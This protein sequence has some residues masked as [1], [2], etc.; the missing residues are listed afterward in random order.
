MSL[1]VVHTRAHLGVTAP[2]V[3][4]E[5]HLSNG[6]PGISIVGMPE[7][8]VRESRER[9]RCAILDS[10]FEYPAR[11]ITVNLAPAALPKSGGRYDLAIAIGILAASGQI[12]AAALSGRELLGELALDGG[13]R[14][15][16]GVLPAALAAREA[17][18]VLLLPE[19][20]TGEVLPVR[21]L[22][23]ISAPDLRGICE[24]LLDDTGS[25]RGRWRT[26]PFD[27]PPADMPRRD[28]PLR[29][30]R[31]QRLAKR[32]ILVAA[33]GGH[34]LLLTGPPGAGKTLLANALY[35]LLPPLSEEQALEVA[36]IRSVNAGREGPFRC[37]GPGGSWYQ[38][39]L[40]APHHKVTGVALTGG[41]ATLRPGEVTLA[42]RGLLFLDELPEFERGALETLREPMEAGAVTVSRVRERLRFP[43][44]FQLVAAMNPCPCGFDGD[45]ENDC[46]CTT[47]RVTR[48]LN[49]LSGP[50]LD[51]FDM[52]VEVPR[53]AASELLVEPPAR[54]E[55]VPGVETVAAC[56]ERQMQRAGMRNASL[57][58]D[59]VHRYCAPTGPAR[60]LLEEVMETRSLSARVVHRLLRTARTIADLD[61]SETIDDGHVAEAIA[62]RN[63]AR[64]RRSAEPE[65]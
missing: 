10:G 49:R 20:N 24:Y 21:G 4:V 56:R 27:P 12:P 52:A 54:A 63:L 29:D 47:D 50:L 51:R 31:G 55:E 9:V 41:G 64:F 57:G 38:P 8:V 40:R 53:L 1:A 2:A 65:T 26:C 34:N 62:C 58:V 39:P 7:T 25:G 5:T 44:D 14:P 23:G 18:H 35:A 28:S 13:L 43:A 48:Y 22:S 59:A 45:P 11:R 33:A 17:G 46:R 61:G 30:V 15:I 42:H 16:E 60:Q 3:I 6:F 37:A 19:A 36:A 32:A